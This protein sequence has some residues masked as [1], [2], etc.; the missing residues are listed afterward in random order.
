MRSTVSWGQYIT[1]H[2]YSDPV[3][4]YSLYSDN[5]E[6]IAVSPLKGNVCFASSQYGFVF[7]L[8]SFAKLYVDTYG[9][10]MCSV[11]V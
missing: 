6:E 10:C 1:L 4:H 7:T 3:M 8:Y 11:C 9:M 2:L 5:T